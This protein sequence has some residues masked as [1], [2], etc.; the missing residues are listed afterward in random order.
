MLRS[1]QVP[2]LAG[3][4][5]ET[6]LAWSTL[7]S[8][9]S[10]PESSSIDLSFRLFVSLT[11]LTCSL[12]SYKACKIALEPSI[13]SRYVLNFDFRLVLQILISAPLWSPSSQ[14]LN[15]NIYTWKDVRG[16]KSEK[17]RVFF[18]CS[19]GRKIYLEESGY[20]MKGR[21]LRMMRLC[22]RKSRKS[23]NFIKLAVILYREGII[24]AYAIPVATSQ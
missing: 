19:F 6:P 4:Q 7:G 17:C 23:T 24:V 10:T 15:S 12:K 3:T 21:G 1:S 18:K 8:T 11:L 22:I 20:E 16:R 14:K 5:S 9:T 13:W 2:V